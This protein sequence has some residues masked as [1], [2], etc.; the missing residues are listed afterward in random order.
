MDAMARSSPD[1]PTDD[2]TLAV[3]LARWAAVSSSSSVLGA[4]STS[5]GAA[6]AVFT[7]GTVASSSTVTSMVTLA[8]APTARPL[9]PGS[10]Q[11]TTPADSAQVQPLLALALTK[12]TAPGRVSVRVSGPLASASPMLSIE[13]VEE[14][15][16]PGD[17]AVELTDLPTS[18]SG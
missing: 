8:E 3:L 11:V 14:R 7:M 9:A 2:V 6:V 16:A 10:W 5:A 15:L 1:P 12:V 4:G 13:I 18:R 17:V